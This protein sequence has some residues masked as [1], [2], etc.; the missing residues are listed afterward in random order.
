[1]KEP[2]RR[3]ADDGIGVGTRHEAVVQALDGEAAPLA[4][5]ASGALVRV[6]GAAPGDALTVEITA[7][8]RK[9]MWGRIRALHQPG[10]VRIEPPCAIVR[11]C[12]TCSWQHISYPEQLASKGRA[13]RELILAQP[14]LAGAVVADPVGLEAPFGYRTKVQ[15][16]VGGVPGDL[17]LGF[18][19]PRSH[20]L[21]RADQ[22]VVQHPLAELARR[23]VVLALNAHR[24]TPYD[25][26]RGEGEVRTVVLRAAPSTG[27]VGVVLV[28]TDLASRDW[29]AVGAQLAAQP[30]ISGVWANVNAQKTNAV[31][32]P[33]TVHLAG[34]EALTDSVRG[35]P[36][37]RSPT[38]FFQTNHR[39]ME[40]L[41]ELIED[42][43]PP[44]FDQW[45]D[46]YAGGGLFTA[47]FGQRAQERTLVESNPDAVASARATLQ[48]CGMVANVIEGRVDEHMD[49]VPMGADVVILDP[50]RSGA[51]EATLRALAARAPSQLIYVSC[52]P[53]ALVRDLAVLATL[54]YQ[55][56]EV[57]SVDMFPH[58]PHLE[59][60]ARLA[61][62]AGR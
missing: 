10:E 17:F 47:A 28:V 6:P 14:S 46:L 3:R 55:T 8:T 13:L 48:A 7:R 12:G 29:A 20:K 39:G 52:R 24:V 2:R 57:R 50:P 56:A 42:M 16:P 36:L 19:A 58:T 45:V 9:G 41:L 26:E 23:Q 53:T 34:A 62:P 60:V 1:M 54:G 49:S 25:E 35:V 59:A 32:G 4:L 5:L 31:L 51:G 37:D 22:C 44:A 15:M 43:L 11:R 30:G 18:W 21:V 27:D 38:S 33:E 40:A 61:A